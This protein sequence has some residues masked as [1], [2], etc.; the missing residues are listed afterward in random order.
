[1]HS[2][3]QD[4]LA[5]NINFGTCLTDANWS[6]LNSILIFSTIAVFVMNKLS[7]DG[8]VKVTVVVCF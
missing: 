6:D 4:L 3:V 2:F 7:N 8:K 1:M 5:S